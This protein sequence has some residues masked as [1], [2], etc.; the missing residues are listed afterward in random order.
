MSSEE[1]NGLKELGA[2]L[3][4]GI[5]SVIIGYSINRLKKKRRAKRTKGEQ[6]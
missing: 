3:L 5:L 2:V 4:I 6:K 1:I